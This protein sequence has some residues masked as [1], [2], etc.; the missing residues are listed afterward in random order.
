MFPATCQ[1]RQ[2]SAVKPLVHGE[3]GHRHCRQRIV[4]RFPL[5]SHSSLSAL[6]QDS[7]GVILLLLLTRALPGKSEGFGAIAG[8]H[9]AQEDGEQVWKMIKSDLWPLHTHVH[10]YPHPQ[11]SSWDFSLQWQCRRW[12]Q[13]GARRASPASVSWAAALSSEICAFQPTL[14]SWGQ[15]N[16][17]IR[18][19]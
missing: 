8:F 19:S 15:S 4:T 9:Q 2:G 10:T 3:M 5:P 17:S 13:G 18:I 11:V 7:H 14:P 6:F 1:C 12:S 16:L